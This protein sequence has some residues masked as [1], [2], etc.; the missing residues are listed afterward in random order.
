MPQSLCDPLGALALPIT[1]N[2][3]L[4]PLKRQAGPKGYEGADKVVQV[5]EPGPCAQGG[6]E[7]APGVRAAPSTWP[8]P[9]GHTGRKGHLRGGRHPSPGEVLPWHSQAGCQDA[10]TMR[11]LGPGLD[12]S[13]EPF[14][15][16]PPGQSRPVWGAQRRPQSRGPNTNLSRGAQLARL[17]RSQTPPPPGEQP[18]GESSLPTI[19]HL[20]PAQ[21]CGM[22][23][24]L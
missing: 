18:P 11:G 16:P 19:A 14:W 1:G 23:S 22:S 9:A 15:K 20:G 10:P 2:Q 12:G 4:Y 13:Q 6:A 3:G 24:E 5:R 8:R 21:P 17:A 7:A